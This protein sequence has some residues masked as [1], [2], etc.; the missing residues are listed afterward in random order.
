MAFVAA[1]L[2]WGA[3]GFALLAFADLSAALTGT[4]LGTL[5]LLFILFAFELNALLA[6]ALFLD[7]PERRPKPWRGAL[8]L[9]FVYIQGGIAAACLSFPATPLSGADWAASSLYGVLWAPVPLAFLAVLLTGHKRILQPAYWFLLAALLCLILAQLEQA[10]ENPLALSCAGNNLC[11]Q[12]REPLHRSFPAAFS[13]RFAI[14]MGFLGIAYHF[15]PPRAE[16]LSPVRWL[17]AAHLGAIVFLYF[18]A[19]TTLSVPVMAPAIAA[20]WFLLVLILTWHRLRSDAAARFV[21]LGAALYAL[22]T[23]AALPVRAINTLMHFTDWTVRS[24]TLPGLELAVSC[25]AIYSIAPVL[26]GRRQLYAP[27]LAMGHFW[28]AALG[29]PLSNNAMELSGAVQRL[30]WRAADRGLLPDY[31]MVEA[32]EAAHPYYAIKAAASVLLAAGWAMMAYN[33]WRTAAR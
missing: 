11:W 13:T 16:S 17:A 1:A 25:G 12:F 24:L 8:W 29:I 20:L 32:I 5:P 19:G 3:A 30:M 18:A 9:A 23:P 14:A 15:A 28:L 10:L 2:V 27:R 7:Y 22:A 4:L 31:W 21:L 33:I 6:A 26:L